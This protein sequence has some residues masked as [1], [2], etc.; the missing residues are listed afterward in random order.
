MEREILRKLVE[1]INQGHV[2]ALASDLGGNT[3]T[4]CIDNLHTHCGVPGGSFDNLVESLYELLV[5]GRGL[6]FAG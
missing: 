6:S 2:I 3:L 1:L 5:N 4:L